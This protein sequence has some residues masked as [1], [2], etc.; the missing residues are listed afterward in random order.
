[1]LAANRAGRVPFEPDVTI[2]GIGAAPR[3]LRRMIEEKAI[4]SRAGP[5][6]GVNY[7]FEAGVIVPNKP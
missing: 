5:V 2:D 3:A 1:M 4:A 6:S 7:S